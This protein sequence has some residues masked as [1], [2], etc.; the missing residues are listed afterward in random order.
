M[1][2]GGSEDE[3]RRRGGEER[4]REGRGAK[5][6]RSLLGALTEAKEER[7]ECEEDA[8]ESAKE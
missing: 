4:R 6:I 2:R 5:C 3:S 1:R 7:Q 8:V